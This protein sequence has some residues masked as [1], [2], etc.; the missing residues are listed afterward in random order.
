MVSLFWNIL[1]QFGWRLWHIG[2]RKV[3]CDACRLVGLLSWVELHV[4]CLRDFDAYSFF[5][6]L[7]RSLTYDTDA[8]FNLILAKNI[9]RYNAFVLSQNIFAQIK[10]FINALSVHK[11]GAQFI[12]S[13][14][15][16]LFSADRFEGHF[17]SLLRTWT[18]HLFFGLFVIVMLSPFHIAGCFHMVAL[19]FEGRHKTRKLQSL[20]HLWG[21]QVSRYSWT[22][23]EFVAGCVA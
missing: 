12:Q 15:L 11:Q 4:K 23:H 2:C 19:F 6:V 13:W 10:L 21:W 3:L 1:A 17:F 22:T 16:K 7:A 20:R 9:V 14:D 18:L 8:Y 5:Q